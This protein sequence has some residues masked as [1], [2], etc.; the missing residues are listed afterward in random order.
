MQEEAILI[1][2]DMMQ[3]C[4]IHAT[5]RVYYLSAANG[6]SMMCHNHTQKLYYQ[7]LQYN[8]KWSDINNLLSVV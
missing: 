7:F 8:Q 1:S 6:T 4:S 2:L 3:I 5:Q